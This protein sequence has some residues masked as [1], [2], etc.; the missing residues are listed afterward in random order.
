MRY[1]GKGKMVQMISK[2]VTY[3]TIVFG[4][5]VSGSLVGILVGPVRILM[6]TEEIG[7]LGACIGASLAIVGCKFAME[8]HEVREQNRETL[9]GPGNPPR[10]VRP[11]LRALAAPRLTARR[12]VRVLNLRTNRMTGD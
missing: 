5:T 2:L 7:I 12:E 11:R 3:A 9:P 6:S 1:P 10:P 8:Q 4:G